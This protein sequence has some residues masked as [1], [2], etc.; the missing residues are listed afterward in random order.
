MRHFKVVTL[1][2]I[3]LLAA[4]SPQQPPTSPTP[5]ATSASAQPSATPSSGVTF[6]V[7]FT[8]DITSTLKSETDRVDFF[9]LTTTGQNGYSL[10]FTQG[11]GQVNAQITFY[12][13]NPPDS[14]NYTFSL[15]VVDGAVTA[16]AF[17]QGQN[18]VNLSFTQGQGLL[19]LTKSD[20]GYSGTFQFTS[21]GGQAGLQDQSITVNGTFAKLQL[22]G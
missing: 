20:D 3:L 18:N 9:K 17:Q 4:C 11:D 19:T 15:D 21:K 22:Q 12:G 8:G 16:Q 5:A 14:G 6:S 7:Q 10:T 2:M 13:A 1:I